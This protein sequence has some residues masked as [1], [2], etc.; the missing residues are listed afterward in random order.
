MCQASVEEVA[1]KE[2]TGDE[3]QQQAQVEA[4]SVEFNR[5]VVGVWIAF[6]G[7]GVS[8]G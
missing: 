4:G 7:S 3:D 6:H 2:H 1:G 5:Q 8:D